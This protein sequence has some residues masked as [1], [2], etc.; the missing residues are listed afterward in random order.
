MSSGVAQTFS[1]GMAEDRRALPD[2]V[3]L[4][5]VAA[6]AVLLRGASS[7]AV[8][9]LARLR[10]ATMLKCWPGLSVLVSLSVRWL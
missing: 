4:G 8:A 10:V 3:F 1:F 7:M 9:V 6:S 5:D 2:R